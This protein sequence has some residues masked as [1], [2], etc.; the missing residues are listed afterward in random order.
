MR[1]A[2][3]PFSPPCLGEDEIGEVADAIRSGWIT[4]GPKVRAFEAAF[5]THVGAPGA[6]ALNSCTA[7][8]H[9]A[10]ATLGIGPGDE[11]ITSTMTFCSTV[12]VIE[13][14]GATPVLVDVEPDTLNLDP[15]LVA[16]AISPRT[17]ALIAVHYAG[18]P[19]SMTRLRELAEAAKLHILEDAAHALAASHEGR[20]IGSGSNPV[21]FS[22]YATKNLATGEGGMLTGD[23]GFLEKARVWSL[24]GMSRDAW[25]RY[26]QGGNWFYE[27]VLPGFK[28]N[29]SDVQAGLGL[30]Q[31]RKLPSFQHRRQAIAAAYTAAFARDPAI[32]TPVVRQSCS[33]AWHLYPIR[34][35]LEQ[36][37]IDRAQF[38][39]EL[40]ALNI[41][42]S[43][44]FIPV[45]RHPYYR[46]RYTLAPSRFPVAE[47]AYW[48]LVSLPM[49]PGL[50]EADANDVIEA[51]I[52][53]VEK[54]RRRK[55]RASSAA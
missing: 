44:H 3:L 39:D 2:F 7:A 4:T 15:E 17:R 54:H 28:Y 27:V 29:M 38:I 26:E 9:V 24:H 1:S 22:F 32:A 36:L 25:K 8:M 48:R 13:Q 16:A 45:H 23:P 33:H 21:A 40:A 18:H 42:A 43:V 19:A 47:D 12:N 55:D 51:V 35:Q 31:L 30:A 20:S 37:L 53:T 49:H 34:L 10:L 41:G 11:V 5:A 46:D 14:V 52:E 6:L 50:T